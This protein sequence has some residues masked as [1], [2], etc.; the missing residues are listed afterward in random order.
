MKI[1]ISKQDTSAPCFKSFHQINSYL[2]I[3]EA[4][5]IIIFIFGV[6]LFLGTLKYQL[7]TEVSNFKGNRAMNII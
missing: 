4:C 3:Q 7:T 1:T 6:K 5:K 2:C